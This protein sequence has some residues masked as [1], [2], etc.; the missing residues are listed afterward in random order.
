MSNIHIDGGRPVPRVAFHA[1][2]RHATPYSVTVTRYVTKGSA[3]YLRGVVSSVDG[4]DRLRGYRVYTG[5]P[6]GKDV[7][8]SGSDARRPRV[9]R[10]NLSTSSTR[11]D[12]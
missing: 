9:L 2:P 10:V 1:T 5:C 3:D 7:S 8:V 4:T 12:T 6:G 11:V